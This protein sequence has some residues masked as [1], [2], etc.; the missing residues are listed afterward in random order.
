MGKGTR[1]ADILSIPQ[2]LRPASTSYIRRKPRASSFK[3]GL[4]TNRELNVVFV[5]AEVAP[6]AKVGGLA[7]VAGSLP[8]AL[9]ALGHRVTVWMPAYQMILD[10]PRWQV[11]DV[12]A[13]VPVEINC[14]WQTEAPGP[15]RG[16]GRS[17]RPPDRRRRTLRESNF[18]R[19][20]LWPGDRSVR[21]LL[22]LSPWGDRRP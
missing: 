14:T 13:R 18:K 9:A 5:S 6:F 21:L 16:H 11:S 20:S 7:D 3:V 1:E 10:D 19:G 12:L 2:T 15:I 4:L 8:K 17:F 22:P